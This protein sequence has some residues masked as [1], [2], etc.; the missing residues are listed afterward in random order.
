MIDDRDRFYRGAAMRETFGKA[1]VNV[2]LGVEDERVPDVV[3]GP[4][5]SDAGT[6]Q[7]VADGRHGRELAALGQESVERV[8]LS[9]RQ[10]HEVQ[11]VGRGRAVT[12][13]RVRDVYPAQLPEPGEDARPGGRDGR[14]VVGYRGA[15]VPGRAAL[16]DLP[17]AVVLRDQPVAG[18]VDRD[19]GLL[20]RTRVVCLVVDELIRA[21][22]HRRL[23][24]GGGGVAVQDGLRGEAGGRR[25]LVW[26]QLGG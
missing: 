4:G 16:H 20:D 25:R 19:P 10:V 2:A 6:P 5:H 8:L 1:K 22:Y 3:D 12:G 11:G 9:R 13:R 21:G 24:K 17:R 23:L 26:G 7:G 18:P 15:P 14:V